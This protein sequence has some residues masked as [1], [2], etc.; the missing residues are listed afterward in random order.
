[1]DNVKQN[2]SLTTKS[3]S[4]LGGACIIA[5]V[6][7]GAGMLG[8]PSAGAGAWIAWTLLILAMT[9]LIMTLSGCFLLEV[10]KNY[11]YKS[12]FDSIT[13]DLLGKP[14][15][16]FNN[17]MI[18]FVGG[19]LLYAYIT[20]SGLII[21]QYMGLNPK[22]AS[23]LFVAVFSFFVWHSTRV[24]DKFSIVL[25]LFMVASFVFGI[26]GLVFNI[27]L[28]EMWR[29]V[30]LEQSKFM[31]AL[32]P[33]ALASFGYHHTVSTMR[34]YYMD[35]RKAQKAIVG[36]T[37]I[38]FFI[39][40]VWLVS[41][42]GNL[43]RM[44]FGE[45]IEKDGDIN[46]LLSSLSGVIPTDFVS[47]VISA[48]SAAA[49]LSSFVGV[50]L[51]VFDFLADVFNFKDNKRGRL[52]TW[53]VTFLPPLIFSLLL[54]FGFLVAIGFAAS[55]AAIWACIIPALLVR[56]SRQS[57]LNKADNLLSSHNDYRAIGGKW[58][59]VVVGVFGVSVITIHILTLT[60]SLP[61]FL[62]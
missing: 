62:G 41:I 56:K 6:C 15:S 42:Y 55:A 54:P 40:A 2:H 59:L 52:K 49:I 30:N 3:P 38:A 5:C 29:D 26:T 34:D 35:E 44:H 58:S 24:V 28:S 13:T 48:F 36:G 8:L 9:M 27:D 16:C 39:Y 21:N 46:V 14:V 11:P 17:I 57:N 10:L 53:S 25:M 50:G 47:N 61:K 7:V 51:G 12:S 23:I 32:V 22:L 1:M 45:I 20:S 60:D 19:I 31:F 4:T 43:P 33:V 18:Y 37:T